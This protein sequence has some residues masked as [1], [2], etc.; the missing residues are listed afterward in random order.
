MDSYPL[1]LMNE[2]RQLGPWIL[3]EKLGQGG[4]ATVWRATREEGGAEVALKLIQAKKATKE[5]YRRFIREIETLRSLGDFPGVLPLLD[6]YLPE[7]PNGDDVPWLAMPIARPLSQAL[8]EATLE[9]IVGAV[10]DIAATLARLSAEHGIGHRDIKPANLYEREGALLVGDF[11]LVAVP[12]V[13]ELTRSGRPLGPA[14][15]T[16]YEMILNPAEAGPHPADVYSL[17]KTL[18]VLATGQAFPPEGH[19]RAGTRGFGIGDFRPHAQADVLDRLIDSM[20]LIHP[21]D[22]PPMTQVSGDLRAWQD[23]TAQPLAVD[24][25]QAGARLR[26]KLAHELAAGERRAT[27]KEHALVAVRRLQELTA[28]L[29][30]ALKRLHPDTEVD[31]MDDKYTTNMLKT[32]VETGAREIEWRWTRCTRVPTGPQHHR[33]SLRMGR[34]LELGSDGTLIFRAFIDVGHPTIGGNDFYW[35]SREREAPTGSIE[36]ERVLQQAVAELGDQLQRAVEVFV[37]KTPSGG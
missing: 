22:R 27:N 34:G 4:N 33:Y 1:Q 19:Q 13:A 3:G 18:W 35:E 9:T 17:G 15:Y 23:L 24:L 6:A 29:N 8:A 5:P 32:H 12:D 20:T 14:H 10:A 11:G 7:E 31:V 37:E 2:P 36:A 26:E 30:E 28:P 21:E 16:P 25:S